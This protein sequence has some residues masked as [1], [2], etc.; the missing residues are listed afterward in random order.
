MLVTV[1]LA[2]MTLITDEKKEV[3]RVI[4][5][6]WKKEGTRVR[7]RK[8]IHLSVPSGPYSTLI[9]GQLSKSGRGQP[10]SFG[11]AD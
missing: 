2:G 9:H 3:V 7:Y 8:V 4:W 6:D 5:S 10:Q 1:K 11:S